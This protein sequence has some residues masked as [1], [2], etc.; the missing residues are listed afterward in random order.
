[1]AVFE[2]DS[3]DVLPDD[4]YADIVVIGNKHGYLHQDVIPRINGQ[5]INVHFTK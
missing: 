1:M 4:I 3:Y 5:E 2:T